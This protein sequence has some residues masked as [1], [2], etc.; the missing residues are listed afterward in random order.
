MQSDPGPQGLQLF[1][2]TEHKDAGI[3]TALEML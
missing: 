2:A 1:A 3:S